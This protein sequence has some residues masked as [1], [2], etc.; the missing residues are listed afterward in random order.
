MDAIEIL[1]YPIVKGEDN[2]VY[3]NH[4]YTGAYRPAGA[5]F[6]EHQN[7]ATFGDLHTIIYGHNVQDGSMFGGLTRYMEEDFFK[8]NG[9]SFYLYTPA[10]IW[11]YDIFSVEKVGSEDPGV[12]TIGFLPGEEYAAFLQG[13]KDR[14][15]YDTGVEV[16]ENDYVITLSTCVTGTSQSDERIVVHAKCMK[17]LAG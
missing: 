9:G 1:D 7:A 17:Q 5:I 14:S 15:V 11:R 8:E 13:M 6:M 10:G 12:Y 16:D 4:S 2:G 3:L